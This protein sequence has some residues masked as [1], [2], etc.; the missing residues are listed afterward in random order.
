[1][2]KRNPISP[3]KPKVDNDQEEGEP[4]DKKTPLLP[5]PQAYYNLV[6]AAKLAKSRI[7]HFT[8]ETIVHYAAMDLFK[9]FTHVPSAFP[10]LLVDKGKELTNIQASFF[11]RPN[12]QPNMLV[13]SKDDCVEI[14]LYGKTEQSDFQT[15]FTYSSGIL[16]TTH[17]SGGEWAWRTCTHSP[18]S[19]CPSD[20]TH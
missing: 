7:S 12:K 17:L 5:L 8:P 6:D 1:M 3:R 4:I 11:N 2:A 18:S 9:L 20:Q 19:S 10:V 15:G 13:L 16:H 14:E